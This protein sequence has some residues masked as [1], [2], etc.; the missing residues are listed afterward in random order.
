M[1]KNSACVK[2]VSDSSR[3]KTR[4]RDRRVG[5]RFGYELTGAP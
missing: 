2:F 1:S 5:A 4:N 3:M